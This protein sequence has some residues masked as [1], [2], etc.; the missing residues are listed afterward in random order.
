M[1]ARPV[2]IENNLIFFFVFANRYKW[3]LFNKPLVA[4]MSRL[5][6]ISSLFILLLRYSYDILKIEFT[7]LWRV[8]VRG[9]K[10]WIASV[11]RNSEY[12]LG[13]PR[14]NSEC[15]YCWNFSTFRRVISSFCFSSWRNLSLLR[16]AFADTFPLYIVCL[17]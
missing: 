10:K 14:S 11:D 4:I 16:E 8:T 6:L 9:L 15:S 12:T 3:L 7:I 2:F 17:A 5:L 1:F 13:E